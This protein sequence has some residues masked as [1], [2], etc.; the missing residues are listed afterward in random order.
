MCNRVTK[1]FLGVL[2]VIPKFDCDVSGSYNHRA[3]VFTAMLVSGGE[4]DFEHP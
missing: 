2:E 1:K 3:K 4:R